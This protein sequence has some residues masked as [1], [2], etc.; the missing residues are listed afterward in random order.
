LVSHHDLA[1]DALAAVALLKARDDIRD[2]QIGLGGWSQGS[3]VAAIAAAQSNDV[4]FVVAV[5]AAGVSFAELCVTRI[6]EAFRHAGNTRHTIKVF[7]GADHTISLTPN[8]ATSEKGSVGANEG[9][10]FAP[11]YLDTMT[12]WL[13]E[14]LGL[15]Q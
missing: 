7:P 12:G 4:A 14:Q 6:R 1:G 11:G 13:R 9:P 15:T 8:P 10:N 2:D 3:W 5:S